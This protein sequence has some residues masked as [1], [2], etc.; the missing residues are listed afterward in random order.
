MSNR[1]DPTADR[2]RAPRRVQ[3]SGQAEV[4]VD[5]DIADVWTVVSDPTRVGEWSHE[6][7]GVSW[8][9]DHTAPVRGA[10]FRGRNHAGVFRWGRICEIVD[11][12]P[13]EI[14]WRT[15]PTALYP[16]SSEWRIAL[17][18]ADGATRIEQTFRVLRAPR[19]LAVLYALAIPSHRDRTAALTDDLRRIGEAA[20]RSAT[21]GR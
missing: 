11:V 20:R 17:T 18:P 10:R 12:H 4:T 6:C 2:A 9:G 7:V 8:M 3:M 21:A 19:V 5:V 16:D 13:H 14:V 15:V 1:T